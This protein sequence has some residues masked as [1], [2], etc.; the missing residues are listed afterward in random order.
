MSKIVELFIYFEIK[1]GAQFMLSAGTDG[2]HHLP[3]DGD[4]IQGPGSI[5]R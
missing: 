5:P 1:I 3:T 4:P 2:Q